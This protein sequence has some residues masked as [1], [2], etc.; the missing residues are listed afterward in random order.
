VAVFVDG[1]F[2]HGHPEHFKPGQSGSYWDR[3]IRRNQERDVRVDQQLI[4]SGWTVL[5]FWDFEIVE[6]RDD[7]VKSVVSA[8][9]TG[10]AGKK[11]THRLNWREKAATAQGDVQV[12]AN[13]GN[14]ARDP[15]HH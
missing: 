7:C 12:L 14:D 2:W 13:I 15:D 11:R 10:S 6:S 1:G 3:K 5:R 4:Q 9:A 8:L